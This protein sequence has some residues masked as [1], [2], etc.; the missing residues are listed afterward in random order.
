MDA[1]SS[2][3]PRPDDVLRRFVLRGEVDVTDGPPA[4]RVGVPSPYGGASK[5]RPLP[6]GL[7]ERT[8]EI[9]LKSQVGTCLRRLGT[10]SPSPRLAR[11][12]R[13]AAVSYL[14]EKDGP[15]GDRANALQL[16]VVHPPSEA[17]TGGIRSIRV[18]D[19]EVRLHTNEIELRP[20]FDVFILLPPVCGVRDLAVIDGTYV[21]RCGNPELR[22][23]PGRIGKLRP[24]NKKV[25]PDRLRKA[26]VVENELL[27]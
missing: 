19:R 26:G 18:G 5:P 1:S 12:I 8:I 7:E 27:I 11:G 2:P 17:Q 21:I 23:R 9:S 20:E 25:G 13:Y 14:R 3:K 6:D 15:T 16:F 4:F 24:D 22:P 10:R